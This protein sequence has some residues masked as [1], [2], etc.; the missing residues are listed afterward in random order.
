LTNE[1]LTNWYVL[2]LALDPTGKFL[3]AG[4]AGDGVFTFQIAPDATDVSITISDNPDP[5]AAG[6]ELTYT[7]TVTNNGP[8]VA[9]EV[10]VTDTLPPDVT[11]V[12][13]TASQGSC[14]GTSTVVCEMGTLASGSSATVTL[15]V[16]PT[17]AG[18]VSNTATV[19]G[20]EPDPQPAN[21]SA[22]AV[23]T[24]TPSTGPD[25]VVSWVTGVLS[26]CKTSDPT[27]RTCQ[28]R[29]T[30]TVENRGNRAASAFSLT[31]HSS[32]DSI[33]DP[34]T[35][36]LLR[37]WDINK[38]KVGKRKTKKLK[39]RVVI[40]VSPPDQYFLIGAADVEN[41]VAEMD[42]GNNVGAVLPSEQ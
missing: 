33:L 15:T 36:T 39:Q 6:S 16:K 31:L 40:E 13:A 9:T 32:A 34:S 17:T 22:T 29:A 30:V 1:G 12:S 42:E 8:A 18:G 10:K 11:L 21:N 27:T 7:L 2:S 24:V 4:T 19:S 38:L 20:N 23:T 3:S 25:L 26:R 5:L 35:D 37:Q 14:S 41:S 28:L